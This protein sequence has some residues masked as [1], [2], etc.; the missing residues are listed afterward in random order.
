M[1][2]NAKHA[3]RKAPSMYDVGRVAGVSQTTVSFIVNNVPNVNI[4]QET[5]DRVWAAVEELGWRPNAMA[6]GLSLQRSHTIGF[7]SDEIVTSS[8]A[9][10]IIQGAQDAAWA[11]A[12]MLLVINTD[13]NPDIERVAV[14]MMLERQVEGL[15]YATMYHRPVTLPPA[16]R[17]V[18]TVLLDC[19]VEDR[20]LPSVVPDEVQG[21]R[22]ATQ[23]LLQK[24]H[25]RIGFINNVDPI[26]ASCGRLE[27]YKQALASYGVPFDPSLVRSARGVAEEGYRCVVELMQLPER[28]TALFCFKDEMAMGAYDAVKQ[29]G[30]SIP[31]DMAIVGFDNLEVIATNLRPPLTT[32]E[33]P[34]YAMGQ[35]AV[36]YLLDHVDGSHLDLI[37]QTIA[38]PLIERASI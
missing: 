16:L 5:R 34:H 14:E 26:P 10:Q 35:Y 1:A 18:P 36:R 4:P 21:G 32:I 33:L 22:T 17:Q 7:I 9:G 3:K 15:I 31:D 30:L 11:E 24:G 13:R 37:Q 12:K 38:C 25:R 6:R 23:A 8:Y 2:Q 29:L 20:S 19:Y 28:P 27:G